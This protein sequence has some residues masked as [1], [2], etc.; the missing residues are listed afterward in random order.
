M[1]KLETPMASA[2]TGRLPR[3]SAL[4]GYFE[5]SLYL[6]LLVSA[7]ALTSTGKL[8]I[9]TMLATP[10]ALLFKGYRWWRGRGPEISNRAATWLMLG[11]LVFFP[12][13]L[14]WVSHGI[15]SDSQNPGL[16]AALLA[17]IH[18]MIFA[19]IVRLFSARST[20]DSL[21]LA[22]LAFSSMLA[23]AILTVD[24]AFIGF[25]IVFLGLCVS[26]FV[27]LEMRRGAEGAAWTPVESGTPA[28][29]RLHK[30]LNLTSSAVAA[31]AVLAGAI[32]FL[33]LPR[34]R[35]GYMSGF[36]LQPGLIAGFS[37]DAELGRIGQIQQSNEVVMRINVDGNPAIAQDMHW[38]GIAF[39]SFDGRRWYT[40]ERQ[41]HAAGQEGD[42]WIL[43]RSPESRPRPR[44]LRLHYTVMLEPIASDAI[45][46]AA[47]PVQIRGQF[48]NAATSVRNFRR[49]Y[50]L[51]DKTGSITNPFHNFS[52]VRYDAI[53]EVP[54][55]LDD[56]LRNSPRTYSNTIR[57]LYLQ[58]PNLDPRIPELARHAAGDAG[59]P[60]DQARAVE[61]Y[62]LANY[63][64]TLDL[65]G[66]PPA[67]PLV[68][69]L[70]ESRAGHCEY[71]ASAMTIMLRTLG[72]PSRYVTGFHGGEYNDV[73][74]DFIIRARHA[75]SWVEAY[76][77]GYGWVTFDPTP[78]GADSPV[79]LM[80]RLS[81]YM[82]WFQLQWSEWVVN[83]DFLHQDAL[84]QTL[85]TTSRDWS[86]RARSDIEGLLNAGTERLR[87][88]QN[89]IS[90]APQWIALAL[91]LSFALAIYMHSSALREW[92]ALAWR[93]R[94]R[95]GPLPPHAAVLS[96][97]RMLR[98]LERRGWH[99]SPDQTPLE[100]AAAIPGG[101]L[102]APVR[103]LTE[104]YQTARFGGRSA[105]AA[106]LA[107]LLAQVQTALRQHE[108]R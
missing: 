99:K 107:S 7:L 2:A 102:V 69:F 27:G 17:A 38:R 60:L 51:Q 11:Y 18:L 61:R 19:M 3:L 32:I 52:D 26:T 66:N 67:D 90:S 91:L 47:E 78:P 1:L 5:T 74:Q 50:L 77:P 33:A 63:R 49:S 85:R 94:V 62:L 42:G 65:A 73:G 40:D 86:G 16:F 46:L 20:R 57:E 24:T 45:F 31:V 34:F 54:R 88:W 58:L 41:P 53:S 101:T 37:D 30:A 12:M 71:F 72:I 106:S 55:D 56:A 6:L 25:F 93:L 21:F 98:L 22:L 28:A 84:A 70:F 15:A 100:F 103:Q 68:R 82:D 87:R 108:R 76:F 29:R 36:N 13:D 8:D 10:A 4:H 105:D 44:A 89:A 14:A 9:V 97:R 81:F 43:L 104:A 48:T 83:Y 35:V 64:Y 96:Y 23:S 59:N 75:H 79:T 92:L 39:T 80:T 95:R